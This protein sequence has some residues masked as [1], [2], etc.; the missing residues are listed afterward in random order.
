MSKHNKSGDSTASQNT[1]G[2]KSV[3]DHLS[4]GDTAAT[5]P[6]NCLCQVYKGSKEDEMY[7]FVDQRDGLERV[8][9]TLL[10]RLGETRL[11]TTL[12]LTPERRLARAQA[13]R[14]MDAI[15]DQGFY[16]QMPPPKHF[17]RDADMTDLGGKNEKMPR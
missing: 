5:Q 15:R 17:Q 2:V 1:S 3:T 11:V 7:L 12:V 4:A 13:S 16:L 8:P 14:V 10:E 9:D 6:E